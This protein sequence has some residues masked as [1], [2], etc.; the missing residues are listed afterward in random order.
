MLNQA[1]RVI[2]AAAQSAVENILSNRRIWLNAGLDR[3]VANKMT[4]RAVKFAKENG[5]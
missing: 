5:L 3:K 4:W 1:Q 2:D